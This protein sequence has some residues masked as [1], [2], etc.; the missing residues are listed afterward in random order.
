MNELT[1]TATI[2]FDDLLKQ[3]LNGTGE[4]LTALTEERKTLGESVYR[5]ESEL[6]G[7]RARLR[8]V[9]T[10]LERPV[11]QA[12]R[13]AELLGVEVPAEY[14]SRVRPSSQPKSAGSYRWVPGP[15]PGSTDEDLR[16]KEY[17]VSKA[18]WALSRGSE[19]SVG[20]H[21]EG[22]LSVAEFW[23]LVERQTGKK[24]ADLKPDDSIE[25][26]LPNGRKLGL[27]RLK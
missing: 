13:A 24:E 5:L 11:A 20:K 6:A 25:V 16:P 4:D 10:K 3:S 27:T 9:E 12:L 2:S 22:A 26:A 19:G 8:E 23:A 18:M 14:S 7:A 17:S 21:G 15:L 1:N